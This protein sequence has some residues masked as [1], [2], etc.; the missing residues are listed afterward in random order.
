MEACIHCAFLIRA[1]E[2]HSQN[3]LVL[4]LDA[5]ITINL[6]ETRVLLAITV[7]TIIVTR[8]LSSRI[9]RIIGR[10]SSLKLYGEAHRKPMWSSGSSIESR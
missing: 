9:T 4:P 5:A 10:K 1:R 7:P 8:L 6:I 3:T 2:R